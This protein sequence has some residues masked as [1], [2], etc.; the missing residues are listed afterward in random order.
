MVIIFTFVPYE[1]WFKQTG[2]IVCTAGPGAVVPQQV[3]RFVNYGHNSSAGNMQQNQWFLRPIM[4]VIVRWFTLPLPLT[5]SHGRVTCTAFIAHCL[6]Q[7]QDLTLSLPLTHSHGR[8]T[9]SIYCTPSTSVTGSHSQSQSHYSD[10]VT[11]SVLVMYCL[12][13]SQ[14]FSSLS[15]SSLVEALSSW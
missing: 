6:R 14:D 7:L 13:Q 3:Y 10:L 5:H 2:F 15:P 8:V 12:C 9:H 1:L 11:L 4:P